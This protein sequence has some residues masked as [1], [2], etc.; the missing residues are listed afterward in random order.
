MFSFL[1]K[2][3]LQSVV[4]LVAVAL[5]AF[6][7]F[8]FVGDPINNMV[9]QDTTL[10]ERE[11]LRES[12]GLN[13]PFHQQFYN[14]MVN[15]AVGDFGISY[16]HKVPVS[17]L[18]A[19]RAPATLELSIISALLSIFIGIPMGVYTAINR[20]GFL[21]RSFMTVSLVGISLPTF[22]IG[23]LF[24]FFFGVILRWL[25]T[26]G[27]GEVV[28]LGWWTTGL[29]TWS[30]I[31]SLILPSITL[32]LFQMTLIM[33]LVRTE[34]LEVLCTDSIKFARARGLHER[35]VNFGHA[36]K[37]TLIPVITIIGL[38]LGL[39]M[40]FAIITETV[41]QWP[42]MGMLF[43]QAME[44]VDVPVMAAYLMM[45]SLIF[46]AIN[47]LVDILYAF[48]DPRLTI[49]GGSKHG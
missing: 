46:V 42:G 13:D 32:A 25:P 28:A 39:V 36:L 34:M 31:K 35:A 41:L 8:K 11:A 33:R 19:E 45:I 17:D 37:N 3:L 4:V 49:D 5:I 23:I 1:V 44:E 9:G 10:E 29:L 16:R 22:L 24:I 47:L 6:S 7:L 2:R 20:S 38:Q 12:L 27:R 15:A 30:G 14:F 26:F 21:S 18:I 40:A 48:V 43:I